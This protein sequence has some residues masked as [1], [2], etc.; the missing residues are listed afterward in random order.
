[1]PR[2]KRVLYDD[3]VS[4]YNFDAKGKFDDMLTMNPLY[5]GGSNRT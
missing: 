4:S 5:G 2:S 3:A 1:M